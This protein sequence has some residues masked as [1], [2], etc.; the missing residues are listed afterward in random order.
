MSFVA[1]FVLVAA[2]G[3]MVLTRI[4]SILY[5]RKEDSSKDI[6]VQI[7]ER[8]ALLEKW[9]AEDHPYFDGLYD[10]RSRSMVS[11]KEAKNLLAEEASPRNGCG[12]GEAEK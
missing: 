12:K 3:M 10:G 11:G 1:P 5:R 2:C 7:A 6:E 8:E 9:Y 4:I